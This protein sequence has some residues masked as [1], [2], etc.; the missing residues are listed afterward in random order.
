[1][2]GIIGAMATETCGILSAM[3]E[4]K[5]EKIGFATFVSGKVGEQEVVL[6]TC[7]IGKVF[8]AACTEAMILKYAPK[9]IINIGVG[10]ALTRSLNIGD[11]VIGT[12][13]VQYDMDTSAIGDPLGWLSGLDLI[14]L[15]C[16]ENL[17]NQLEEALK[18][19]GISYQKGVVA[20]ADRF[21]D[22]DHNRDICRQFGALVEDMEGAAVGQVCVVHG[23]PFGI[24][25]T[26]SNGDED[27]GAVYENSAKMASDALC[28]G[29]L[30]VFSKTC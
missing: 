2:I 23:V 5:T 7:G 4:T 12:S 17:Q 29:V 13:A 25:R 26:I 9:A 15:P 30:K 27:A 21:V 22:D 6:A 10:G 14:H 3:T 16:D 1:M 8:A 18:A 19:E 28:R 11:G 20:T 24:L